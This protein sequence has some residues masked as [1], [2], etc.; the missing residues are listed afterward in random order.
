MLRVVPDTNVLISAFMVEGNEYRL[1]ENGFKK[2]I[3]LITSLAIIEEFKEVARRPRIGFAKE[4]I[5]EFIDAL[6]EVS[7]L[8][9]P[10]QII[11]GICRDPDDEKLLEAAVEGKADY[12]VSGDKDWL[13][14]RNFRG[15]KI[16]S[17][18]A[19]L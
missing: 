17:A 11:T 5:D 4:D 16:V 6:L 18:A 2:E 1:I 3:L 15:I 7:K 13:S 14:L 19:L 9:I 8:V 12:I 10:T